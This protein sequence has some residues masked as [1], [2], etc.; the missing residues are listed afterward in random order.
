MVSF[1]LVERSD[2]KIHI[3]HSLAD[4]RIPFCEYFIIP[5]VL[6]YFFL[7]GTVIYFA[8]SCPSKKEYYQYLATLGVGMTLFLLISYVYP[9]GQQ[10]RSELTGDGAYISAVRFLYKI[11]TPTNIFPSMHVFNATASCIALYQNEKCRKNRPFTMAQIVLTVSIILS[12]MFLKQHSVADVMTAL[13]L[14]ILCYQL[15]YK[16]IPAR[17]DQLAKIFTR[18]EIFTVPNLLSALRLCLAIL[19]LGVCERYGFRANRSF[20]VMIIILAAATDFLDG[21]IAR[22]FHQ[23]SRVGRVLDPVADKAMQGVMLA[24]LMSS[25]PLVELVLILFL[26]KEFTT[27]VVGWKVVMETEKDQEAQWHGKLNTAVSYIVVLILTA[28]S[29]LPYSTGNILIGACAVCMVMSFMMYMSQFRE[30][31]AKKNGY[32]RSRFYF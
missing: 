18:K 11:D 24:C 8:L 5:Y 1:M 14:N 25:Y 12:T 32:A 26:V 30:I 7:I 6:W 4:D 17:Q 10:L 28:G 16:I 13:I 27:L 2:V 3:I 29:R 15:F 19:F 23:V 22:S 9:N 31:L 20:L 21:R